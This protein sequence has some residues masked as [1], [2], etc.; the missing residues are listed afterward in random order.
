MFNSSMQAH[1]IDTND[2]MA[3]GCHKHDFKVTSE[4]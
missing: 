2:S 1:Q 3:E 4:N